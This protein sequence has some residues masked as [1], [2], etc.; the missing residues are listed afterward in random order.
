MYRIIND[1]D[2]E[3]YSDIISSFPKFI[4]SVGGP[5]FPSMSV[6][7]KHHK[8]DQTSFIFPVESVHIIGKKDEY[9]KYMTEN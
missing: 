5:Y 4:I 9:Y 8:F 1:I 6:N 2:P 3:S 7:Y